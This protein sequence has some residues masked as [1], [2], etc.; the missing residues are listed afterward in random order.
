MY[1]TIINHLKIG[2]TVYSAVH[3]KELTVIEYRIGH[4]NPIVLED[5]STGNLHYFTET[6]A[7]VQGGECMLFP[8][9]SNRDW[10]VPVIYTIQESQNS[11]YT[12]NKESEKYYTNI[13][14]Q[15]T[16]DKLQ[17]FDKVLV[18]NSDSLPW[19]MNFFSHM[20]GKKY[21]VMCGIEY[22]QCI[23]Y[24]ESTKHLLKNETN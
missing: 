2:Q 18:R 6:G 15:Y 5:S 7:Y 12:I 9:S 14:L 11:N 3:G 21:V 24:N 8:S 20:N 1:N 17:P 13:K 16:S 22:N 10:N 4:V 23:R 19:K